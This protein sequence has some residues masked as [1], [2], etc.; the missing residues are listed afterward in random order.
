MFLPYIYKGKGTII[1][2]VKGQYCSKPRCREVVMEIGAS[3][4][5]SRE[6]LAFNK[7]V[8]AKDGERP[9]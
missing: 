2:A 5:A 7:R 4:R 3:V 9:S 6:M 1:E 8:N